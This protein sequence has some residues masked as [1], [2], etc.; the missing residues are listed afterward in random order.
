MAVTHQVRP[1]KQVPWRLGPGAC[2]VAPL[3]RP[4]DR[5]GSGTLWGLSRLRGREV[6]LGPTR[7]PPPEPPLWWVLESSLGRDGLSQDSGPP[8]GRHVDTRRPRVGDVGVPVAVVPV[9]DPM[10]PPGLSRDGAV[11]G[12]PSHISIRPAVYRHNHSVS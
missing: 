8:L 11:A 5:C 9:A 12:A 6:I 1:L 4:Y 10:T 3:K 7:V 2:T